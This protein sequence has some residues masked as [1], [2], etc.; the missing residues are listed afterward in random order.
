MPDWNK[1]KAGA[2]LICGD[3]PFLRHKALREIRVAQSERTV[4]L[5]EPDA[6]K[7]AK[8]WN[9]LITDLESADMMG[10]G[11]LVEVI[12]AAKLKGEVEGFIMW[13][14]DPTD[15]LVV[16]EVTGPRLKF[17]KAI[18]TLSKMVPV[19]E[20][21]V[22]KEYGKPPPVAVWLVEEARSLGITLALPLAEALVKRYRK[23]VL[24]EKD[25]PLEVLSQ[26]IANIAAFMGWKGKVTKE[27]LMLCI[28]PQ[29]VAKPFTIID[30]V[31][32]GHVPR[33]LQRSGVFFQTIGDDPRA[34]NSLC[35]TLEREA[36]KILGAQAIRH[37]TDD[38]VGKLLGM[39][40]YIYSISLKPR[41]STLTD[42]DIVWLMS[43]LCEL[44]VSIRSSVAS[45]RAATEALL[46]ELT[47]R[48]RT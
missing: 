10:S 34:C 28:S 46:I 20:Y 29:V 45:P 39:H 37:L 27:I 44:E 31:F 3:E 16:L 36:E 35:A 40:P 23:D 14:G 19:F 4:V 2:V 13:L 24:S 30:A 6:T 41:L 26:E 38:R 21:N 22:L 32:E 17:A 8:T 18:K 1:L 33:M 12:G 15:A 11:L 42:V 5:V 47:Q 7:K 48:V 9:N 25:N 43:A